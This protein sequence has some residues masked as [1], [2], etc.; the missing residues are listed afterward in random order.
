MPPPPPRPLCP[1]LSAAAVPGVWRRPAA[2]HHDAPERQQAR[3]GQGRKV[4]TAV[5]GRVAVCPA[6]PPPPLPSH[7]HTRLH[8]AL[9]PPPGAHDPPRP[10]HRRP[11]A[12]HPTP[13]THRAALLDVSGQVPPEVIAGLYAACKGGGFGSLQKAVQARSSE[14]S[15]QQ[16]CSCT[17]MCACSRRA[18]VRA[19]GG[20]VAPAQGRR[21]VWPTGHARYCARATHLGTR[22]IL[23]FT[24][25]FATRCRCWWRPPS[26]AS[27]AG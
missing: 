3:R 14:G 5:P 27:P 1:L 24:V 6:K 20:S 25:A 9:P 26:A 13:N 23:P 2:G 19:A 10:P 22:T 15:M 4:S 17:Y 18:H 21:V 7:T 8:P 16:L 11:D 12:P